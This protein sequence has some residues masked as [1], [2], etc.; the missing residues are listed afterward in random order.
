MDAAITGN[1]DRKGSGKDGADDAGVAV[2]QSDHFF[3]L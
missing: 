1:R 2:L 3:F